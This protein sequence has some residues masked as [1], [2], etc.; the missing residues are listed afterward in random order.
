MH[1]LRV[2]SRTR[3]TLLE[4]GWKWTV[5]GPFSGRLMLRLIVRI[6]VPL[7]AA[8][9]LRTHCLHI[10]SYIHKGNQGSYR[11]HVS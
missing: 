8:N 10:H 3:E 5:I 11:G 6:C 2:H 7:H 9:L 1:I 4:L